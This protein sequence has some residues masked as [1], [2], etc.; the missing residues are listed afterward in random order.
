MRRT[1]NG[2]DCGFCCYGCCI[3]FQVKHG[4]TEEWEAAWL[5]IRLGVGGFL[6][7]NIMLFSLLLYTDAFTGADA[8]LIPWVHILLWIFATPAV[9]I[10]G[11]PFLHETWLNGLQGRLTSSALIVIGVGASYVYSAVAVIERGPHV[12]FDTAT[13]VLM[14]FTLGR[15]LEAAGRAR[16]ARDLEPLLAAERESVVVVQDGTEIRRPVREVEAGMLVRVR[17][18]ERIAIDGVVVEGESHTDEAV[19]TGESRLVA[20]AIGSSVAAGSINLDGPLLIQSSGAGTATRWAQICRSVRD[21]LM[22]RSPNQRVADR[23]VGVF[24]PFVLILGGATALYWGQRMPFD[25]ALLIGLAVLVVACPCAVGLAA[26]L[27]TSLGIGRLA[28]CGCL[29]RDPAALEALACIRLLA[30][31]KTGTLTMGRPRVVGIESDGVGTDEVLARAA[32]LERHSEHG[33]AHAIGMAAATRGLETVVARDVRTVPGRGIHGSSNGQLVAAGNSALMS[34]LGWPLPQALAEL[35]RSMEVSGHSVV[36][37]GWGERV[38]AVLSFDDTPLAEARSTMEAL[39]RRGLHV[40]LLTGD[41]AQAAQRVAAAVGIKVG[42]IQAGLSPEAKLAALNRYRQGDEPVAMV[43]DGLNDA[44]VLAGVDVGIAVG[45]ATDLARETA[46]LVLPARGLWLLP[47]VVDVARAVRLTILT[48][49]MWAFGYN[50]VALTL[51]VLG[52]LQPVLAAAVMAGSSILV[53]LNSLR[54]ERLPDPISL[55]LP[56]RLSGAES[57]RSGIGFPVT[58]GPVIERG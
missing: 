42:D 18:G 56:Q 49:L 44:P 25:R 10:L 36:Y 55:P 33:L 11:G 51:A 29:V 14:L 40:A 7:M 31:D 3:A 22:R 24:V 20:K 57:A 5:L 30:F 48:N 54:L 2:E 47:W 41:L 32:G 19:I 46:A 39:R 1:V 17:P 35:A 34:D 27:A 53:V 16:A 15:L 13:M 28:R 26:P 50:L 9:I 23:V 52:L 45:S 58:L 38:H 37:V 43:G 4:K 12:Y 8:R 21:A 6:S